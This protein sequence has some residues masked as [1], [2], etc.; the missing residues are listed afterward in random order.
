MC[1]Y[2]NDNKNIPSHKLLENV[3][4]IYVHVHALNYSGTSM[5]LTP[6][7]PR[8]SVLIIEV[9][10]SQKSG[11]NVMFSFKSRHYYNLITLFFIKTYERMTKSYK[12]IEINKYVFV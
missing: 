7:G 2:S 10:S 4:T 3:N 11:L 5:F 6:L 12:S 8:S 9:S 1:M